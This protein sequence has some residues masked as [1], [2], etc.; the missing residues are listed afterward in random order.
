M[1][2]ITNKIEHGPCC[3]HNAWVWPSNKKRLP[4]QQGLYIKYLFIIA[5]SLNVV[6]KTF[7]GP[8]SWEN[9][10]WKLGWFLLG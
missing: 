9:W 5:E 3:Q 2:Y 10:R 6:L 8:L 1:L 4:L 7:Y